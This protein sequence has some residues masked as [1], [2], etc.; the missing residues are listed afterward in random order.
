MQQLKVRKFG[1]LKEVELNIDDYMIFVGPQASGKSTILKLLYIFRSLQEEVYRTVADVVEGMD[2]D[3]LP[4]LKLKE[5]IITKFKSFWDNHSRYGDF[6]LKY[7]YGNDKI[8]TIYQKKKKIELVLSNTLEQE[9]K[10]I[11]VGLRTFIKEQYQHTTKEHKEKY[12][13]ELDKLIFKLF[14]REK[15]PVYIPAGRVMVYGIFGRYLNERLDNTMKMFIQQIAEMRPLYFEDLVKMVNKKKAFNFRDR[16]SI[17][18]AMALI[19]LILRGDYVC[20]QDSERIIVE[21]KGAHIEMPFASTGQQES[22]WLMMQLFTVL[23]SGHEYFLII[24]E[25]E[26]HLHPMAQRYMMELI[27]LVKNYTGNEV[28]MATNSPTV[29]KTVNNQ[30]FAGR[31]KGRE[32]MNERFWLSGNK[33]GV[34]EVEHEELRSIKDEVRG[35]IRESEVDKVGEILEEEMRRM[36]GE[37]VLK[38]K[39][40]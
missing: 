10:D 24:D 11:F 4:E 31:K 34:Y 40:I 2:S 12:Y 3:P 22:L 7:D 8:V 36:E 35:M 15:I 5:H 33:L 23:L 32:V 14:D 17:D 13:A 29:L 20:E 38:Q 39:K 37:G 18:M 30:V 16:E 9:I 28:M 27:A 1:P 19:K 26:A 6:F 21:K 25:P